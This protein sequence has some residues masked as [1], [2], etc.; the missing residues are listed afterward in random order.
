MNTAIN[1]LTDLGRTICWALDNTTQPEGCCYPN[2][3]KGEGEYFSLTLR[4]A[5]ERHADFGTAVLNAGVFHRAPSIYYPWTDSTVP[6]PKFKVRTCA[7]RR[8]AGRSDFVKS[9]MLGSDLGALL[10]AFTGRKFTQGELDYFE[11]RF[12]ELESKR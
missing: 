8:F 7:V 5:L 1:A 2:L 3:D 6:S 10:T 12:E 11:Q 4:D 9:G